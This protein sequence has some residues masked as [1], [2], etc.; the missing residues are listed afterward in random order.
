VRNYYE[1]A[2]MLTSEEFLEYLLLED[3]F[4]NVESS[5]DS[6]EKKNL[7][8]HREAVLFRYNDSHSGTII[9]SGSNSYSFL[10]CHGVNKP[11]SLYFYLTP[12]DLL[13]WLSILASFVGVHII[14]SLVAGR[15]S[16]WTGLLLLAILLE[17]SVL[18][19][20]ALASETKKSPGVKIILA[21]W[22][23]LAIVITTGYKSSFTT[24]MTAPVEPSA[25]WSTITDLVDFDIFIPLDHSDWNRESYVQGVHFHEGTGPSLFFQDI[26][27]L[28][29]IARTYQGPSK[30][31]KSHAEVASYLLDSMIRKNNLMRLQYLMFEFPEDFVN[32]LSTCHKVAYLDKEEHIDSVLEFLN[33]NTKSL[34]FV[35]GRDRFFK[36]YWGWEGFPIRK[37]YVMIRLASLIEAG[38]QSYWDKWFKRSKPEKLFQ[39]YAN[40]TYPT[41]ERVQK[42]D[43]DSKI[44]TSFRIYFSCFGINLLAFLIEVLLWKRSARLNCVRR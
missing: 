4:F 2:E 30:V 37:N 25:P 36:T 1:I 11:K 12:Y 10:S 34:T 20:K 13:S 24:E 41:V 32:N 8:F 28:I 15:L 33:D 44:S 26:Y 29:S 42:L 16:V 39:H 21:T 40:W 14:I 3:V 17:S 6:V 5:S 18:C 23:L 38:I 43:F 27:D 9:L 19:L 22:V 35:K 7:D 31:L